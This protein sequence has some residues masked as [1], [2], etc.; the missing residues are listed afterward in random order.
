MNCVLREPVVEQKE[1]ETAKT[2]SNMNGCKFKR[3]IKELEKLSGRQAAFRAKSDKD[4]AEEQPTFLFG[5]RARAQLIDPSEVD[6]SIIE[7]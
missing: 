6:Y 7:S 4:A 5:N 1:L 2:S 3:F